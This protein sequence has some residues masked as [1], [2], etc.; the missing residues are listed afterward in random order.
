MRSGPFSGW[1]SRRE[2]SP[3]ANPVKIMLVNRHAIDIDETLLVHRFGVSDPTCVRRPGHF[4]KAF[5]TPEGPCTLVISQRNEHFHIETVGDGDGWVKDRIEAALVPRDP[6]MPSAAP[7]IL[8][9]LDKLHRGLRVIP[10]L[11]PA[12]VATQFV[13]QQRIRY[14]DAAVQYRLMCQAKPRPAPGQVGLLLPPRPQDFSLPKLSSFG[15]DEKR[16]ST[17]LRLQ[18]FDIAT[19]EHLQG[20]GPWTCGAIRAFGLG[21]P[22]AVPLGDLHFPH[23]VCQILANTSPRGGSDEKMLEL[24]EPCRGLRFRA[25]RLLL[26]VRVR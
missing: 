4:V 1:E 19:F 21:D 22:D 20:I 15:I 12:D 23:H 11:W 13:L 2:N 18:R 7:E 24:L 14:Q 3:A 26:K 25:L 10:V 8:R 6:P 16:G 9:K 17:I 5:D